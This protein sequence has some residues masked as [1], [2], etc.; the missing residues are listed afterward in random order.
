MEIYAL[1]D[2]VKNKEQVFKLIKQQMDFIGSKKTIEDINVSLQNALSNRSARLVVCAEDESIKGFA[3]FNLASGLES[4]GD[5]IWI[6]ELFVSPEY[7]RQ[8]IA[9]ALLEAIESFAKD[10]S[11]K[12]LALSTS[13]NNANARKLYQELGFDADLTL[14]VDKSL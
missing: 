10:N 2:E 4:G 7:R 12:Y 3:F 5:Y 11:V 6:N 1:Y 13:T 8:G 14:W 9:K